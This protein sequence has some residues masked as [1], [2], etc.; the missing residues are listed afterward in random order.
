MIRGRRVVAVTL[1][2]IA[3][4]EAALADDK[5]ACLD[6]SSEGQ[7]LRDAHKL[8]EARDQFRACGRATCPAVVLRDCTAWLE[9]TDKDIPSLALTAKDGDGN[10]LV[11]VKVT[12]DG[13]VV[14]TKLDGRSI[15][16]N[17]GSHALHFELADGTAVDEQVLAHEGDKNHVVTA[18]LRKPE[19]SQVAAVPAPPPSPTEPGPLPLASEVSVPPATSPSHWQETTGN[20]IGGV[21]VVG[22][23]VGSI[24]GLNAS[25]KWS[26]AQSDCK[27][28]ACG[29]G[30]QYAKDK[31]DADS[32]ATISTIAFVA[33]G[34][35][36]ATGAVL[37]FTAPSRRAAVSQD[38]RSV[39]VMPTVGTG[40][41][42]L[43]VRGGF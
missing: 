1:A 2:V 18:V 38:P 32:A 42:G 29:P 30:S 9:A 23:V 24:F 25:S 35:A 40:S 10:D 31:T 3:W 7:T 21:G 12:L 43:L 37:F 26:E 15:E 41:G 17:T 19:L 27:P 14:A 6:A 4:Q 39:Q 5:Q 28:G 22:L 34:V 20:V 8:L 13:V 16:V 33:G 36:L 11:D